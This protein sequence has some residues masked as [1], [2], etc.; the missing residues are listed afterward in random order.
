[1]KL[2][3]HFICIIVFIAISTFFIPKEKTICSNLALENIEALASGESGGNKCATY[4]SGP[5][6]GRYTNN[7]GSTINLYYP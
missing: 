5:F 4:Y 2:K 7:S 1:M 6:C 3:N